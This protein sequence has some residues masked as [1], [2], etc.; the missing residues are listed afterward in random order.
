MGK[1]EDYL[2]VSG[3]VLLRIKV[4]KWSLFKVVNYVTKGGLISESF[5][6]LKKLN[7]TPVLTNMIL[8]ECMTYQRKRHMID[9]DLSQKKFQ[10]PKFLFGIAIFLASVK[11]KSSSAHFSKLVTQIC[12]SFFI[13]L[14]KFSAPTTFDNWL[15]KCKDYLK[16]SFFVLLR[17]KVLKMIP[18]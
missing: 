3:F 14:S 12:L 13:S 15:G 1:C 2:K 9:Y 6:N 7:M 4:L 10:S 16:V 11:L 8:N 5:F 18:T 17:I